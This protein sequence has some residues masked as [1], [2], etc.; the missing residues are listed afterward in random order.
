MLAREAAL[1]VISAVVEDGKSLSAAQDMFDRVDPP[2]DRA[3]AVELT[4]G[5]LRW[6]WQL[7]A[8]TSALL[9]KPLRRRDQSV[10]YIIWLGLYQ[11]VF[12]RV[13]DHAAVKHT[14]EI[15]RTTGKEWASGVVNACLRRFGREKEARIAALKE[16]TA[17]WSYPSWWIT[18]LQA[19]WP[20]QWEALASA[21]NER[22]PMTLRVNVARTSRDAL[23]ARFSSQNIPA[24]LCAYSLS[25]FSLESAID[26]SAIPG[27]AQGHVSVQ[28]E[29]AQLCAG[30]LCVS[31]SMRVLDACAAP[32]GKATHLS[33]L[34]PDADILAV[35]V[36]ESRMGRVAENIKRLGA[37][38]QTRVG[39]VTELSQWWDGALFDRI[40]VDSPCSA[41]GVVRRHPDIKTLRRD[42]DID[43]LAHTQ[44][45]MLDKLWP[46]LKP[47]GILLYV[48]CSIFRDENDKVVEPFVAS[49]NDAVEYPIDVPWGVSL[50]VGRQILP[51]EQGMD[52]FYFARLKK[53]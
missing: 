51:G 39:D 11:M 40:L 31:G 29:A 37:R 9:S 28:D 19:D 24:R 21:G 8:L 34:A 15:A 12:M 1:K 20:E 2:K 17:Q 25:G 48:T 53:R 10:R 52:G 30:L 41:S 45:H 47:G 33:E 49:T 18:R 42:A 13:A 16:P 46:L 3:L 7:D 5:V 38:L 27:F 44:R 43:A 4:Y 22:A 50:G 14:V 35:E 26:V 23:Q 6:R 32:G 36:D